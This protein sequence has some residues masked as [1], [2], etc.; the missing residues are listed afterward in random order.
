[1][2]RAWGTCKHTR[3]ASF[4]GWT[5][6]TGITCADCTANITLECFAFSIPTADSSLH[7][8]LAFKLTEVSC[9]AICTGALG[10]ASLFVET[11]LT[12]S[13]AHLVAH[14]VHRASNAT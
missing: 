14:R 1:M 6:K 3:A 13:T 11:A 10:L 9:K 5:G 12:I 8:F 4:T 7:I 2:A